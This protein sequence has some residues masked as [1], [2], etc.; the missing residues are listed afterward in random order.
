[1]E[2]DVAHFYLACLLGVMELDESQDAWI[3]VK[4]VFNTNNA[5][6]NCLYEI[7]EQAVAGGM[8]ERN[9]EVQYRWNREFERHFYWEKKHEK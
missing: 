3:R 1:M 5:V 8:L 2:P 9:D 7:L 6:S 4:G